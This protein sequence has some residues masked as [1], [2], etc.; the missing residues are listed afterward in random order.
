MENT[1]ISATKYPSNKRD[2]QIDALSVNLL[3]I[4]IVMPVLDLRLNLLRLLSQ[5]IFLQV[6]L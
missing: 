6:H 2:L 5:P 4:I 3:S 1:A